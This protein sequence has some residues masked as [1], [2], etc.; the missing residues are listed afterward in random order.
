LKCPKNG[1][2]GSNLL[3]RA[4]TLPAG[5]VTLNELQEPN[6]LTNADILECAS[7]KD[8]TYANT[9]KHRCINFILPTA[10]ATEAR[11]AE[12]SASGVTQNDQHNFVKT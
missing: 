7:S 1:S 11:E 12:K 5:E 10:G 8:N 2:S 4:T 9:T 3:Q 6:T